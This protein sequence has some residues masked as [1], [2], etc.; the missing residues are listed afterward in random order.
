MESIRSHFFNGVDLNVRKIAFVKCDNVLASKEKGGLGISSFYALNRALIIK[1]VWRFQT[2]N[3]SLW[4]RV[5]KAIHGSRRMLGI[6]LPGSIKK[7]MGNGENTMFWEETW[8]GEAPLKF[9]YPRFYVLEYDKNISVAAKMAHP[10]FGYS[11]RRNPRGGVEQVQMADML[12]KMEGLI[13]P[14]MLD[15]WFW[16]HLGAGEFI[17]F[18]SLGNLSDDKNLEKWNEVIDVDALPD[19]VEIKTEE[20]TVEPQVVASENIN[21]I[22]LTLQESVNSSDQEEDL[23]EDSSDQE[24]FFDEYSS[25]LEEYL[26]L[27]DESDQEENLGE[28]D[29]DDGWV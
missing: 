6:D 19:K 5:I 8:L 3:T 14:N 12:S 15:R 22:N 1:W 20:T 18:F 16:S 24:E 13:L 10:S 23:Y 9:L 25:D 28:D 4:S 21:V 11:F 7:K 29:S 17:C 2:Q 27:F 26:G